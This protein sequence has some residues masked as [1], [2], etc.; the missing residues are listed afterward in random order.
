MS[1]CSAKNVNSDILPHSVEKFL[2][3]NGTDFMRYELSDKNSD[4][5]FTQQSYEVFEDIETAWR[6]YVMTDPVIAFS[7]N[8]IDF[9]IVY[10]PENSRVYDAA[11]IPVPLFRA[12]QIYILNLKILGIY[13]IPVAFEVTRLDR[14]NKMIE[15]VYLKNNVSNGYQQIYLKSG[16]DSEGAPVTLVE[17]K[18]FFRSGC[19]FR[20]RILYPPFHKLIT[21]GFHENILKLNKADWETL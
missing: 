13:N 10:N 9:G 11:D 20:D 5:M 17:H 8:I 6:Y 12:G 4:Y 16:C 15:F 18:S 21:R 2:Q 19:D 3:K 1:T 14:E 7:N